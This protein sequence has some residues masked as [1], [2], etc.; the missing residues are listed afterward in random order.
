M[1]VFKM[2]KYGFLVFIVVLFSGCA[3]A[4]NFSPK[5]DG[6]S[7][8]EERPKKIAIF[9]DGTANDPNSDTNVKQLHSLVSL[10][11]R[12]DIATSYIKGVG[13]SGKV[14]GMAMGWGIGHDVREAYQFLLETYNEN[15]EIYIFGF[16]RGAYASRILSAIL[17][18]GGIPKVKPIYDKEGKDIFDYKAL[19]E[20]VYSAYKGE[21]STKQRNSEILEVFKNVP[22]IKIQN[23]KPV[24]VKVLGLWDTVEALGLPNYKEDIDVPNNRYGDQLCNVENAYQA[25]SIDDDRANVFTPLLITRTHM[26]NAC[27]SWSKEQKETHQKKHVKEVYFSGAHSD[28]GGGYKNNYL[29]G[30]SLNWMISNIQSTGILPENSNVQQNMYASTHDPESGIIWGILYHKK[31]RNLHEYIN[32]KFNGKLASYEKK[33]KIHESVFKRLA[34]NKKESHEYNWFEHYSECFDTAGKGK[35]KILKYKGDAFCGG[36]ETIQNQE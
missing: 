16:S 3:T 8:F 19:S 6:D 18:Y 32:R 25:V 4:I 2:F 33:L 14:L 31:N 34:K 23:I 36:L 11:R 12:N 27:K 17:Y 30:V 35:E 28:V 26:Y 13:T 15:D 29:N 9:F 1:S 20:D 5:V 22:N 21:K 10:Q 24:H 7:R